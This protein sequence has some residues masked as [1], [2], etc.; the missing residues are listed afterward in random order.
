M[1]DKKTPTLY[2]RCRVNLFS[3]QYSKHQVSVYISTVKSFEITDFQP[4]PIKGGDEPLLILQGCNLV[5]L[6]YVHFPA[7]TPDVMA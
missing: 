7:F 3:L 2:G 5:R 1:R 6:L 4:A